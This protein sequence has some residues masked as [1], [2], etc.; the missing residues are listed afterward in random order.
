LLYCTLFFTHVEQVWQCR[1]PWL[2]Q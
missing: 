2:T 1:H